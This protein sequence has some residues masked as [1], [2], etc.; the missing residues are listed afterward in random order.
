[1]SAGNGDVRVG[2]LLRQA[3]PAKRKPLNEERLARILETLEYPAPSWSDFAAGGASRRRWLVHWFW[4]MPLDGLQWLAFHVLSVLPIGFVSGFGGRFARLAAPRFFPDAVDRALTNL[5]WLE[6]TWSEAKVREVAARHFEGIGRLRAEFCVLHRLLPAGRISVENGELARKTMQEGPVILVGMHV[7]NWEVLSPVMAEFGIPVFDVYEPQPSRMQTRLALRVRA[8]T[9]PEGS[10][11][12]ARNGNAAR[13][14]VKWLK[15]GGTLI[16]FC[17]EAVEWVSVAPFFGRPPHLDSNYAFTARLAR[18]TDATLLPFH[19]LR[20]RGCRFTLRFGEPMRLAPA[21]RPGD[22]LLE[23]V[24][25]LNGIVEPVVRAHLD[26]WF[27][28][29]WAFATVRYGG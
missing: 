26:Q 2:S 13:A 22:C 27:W 23:D 5:R 19:V 29:D 14:A 3:R 20:H 10:V 9:G 6:P 15:E 24:A 12:Y 21:E 1:M 7:A 17:D 4:D 28:L 18:M 25:Q 11:A 8:R 16:M